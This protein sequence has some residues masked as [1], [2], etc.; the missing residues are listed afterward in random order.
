MT[1]SGESD[2]EFG[3]GVVVCLAKFSEHLENDR[4]T[5]I[6]RAHRWEQM[7]ERERE[8]YRA[9]ATEHPFGDGGQ[10]VRATEIIALAGG[11][12]AAIEMWANGAS[13][14]FY[15]LDERAH[16][17]L[18]ELAS[19]TLEVGHG[20]TGKTWTFST[21]ERIRELWRESCVAVDQALGVE[22]DWGQW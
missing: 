20:F 3:R 11:L 17:P 19:L 9:S 12:S 13:D 2:S 4:A 5:R 14:H 18:K 16:T 1:P 7:P 21:W 22:P 15:D 6:I 10:M 8:R